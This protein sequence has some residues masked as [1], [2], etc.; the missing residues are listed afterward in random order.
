[1]TRFNIAALQE[2]GMTP[3]QI[4]SYIRERERAMYGGPRGSSAPTTP[5]EVYPPQKG[6]QGSHFSSAGPRPPEPQKTTSESEFNTKDA[7]FTPA[8]PQVTQ[9]EPSEFNTRDATFTSSPPVRTS[10]ESSGFQNLL[11]EVKEKENRR[12]TPAMVQEEEPETLANFQAILEKLQ[13]TQ[14]R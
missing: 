10:N 11:N 8:P 13:G 2:Q 5:Q 7:T 1:M 4:Q 6:Q 3:E 12:D 14:S 9:S